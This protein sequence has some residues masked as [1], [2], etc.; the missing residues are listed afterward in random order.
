MTACVA[1]V[2]CGV[3]QGSLVCVENHIGVIIH[4]QPSEIMAF[5]RETNYVSYGDLARASQLH[6]KYD[7]FE[8]PVSNENIPSFILTSINGL[9]NNFARSCRW[10]LFFWQFILCPPIVAINSINPFYAMRCDVMWD[11][12]VV[13]E[14]ILMGIYILLAWMRFNV[15]PQQHLCP[16]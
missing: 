15:P 10:R 1:A 7:R 12:C 2:R 3:W 14:G 8:S 13:Y 11:S 5:I 4:M 6:G 9:R 16:Q